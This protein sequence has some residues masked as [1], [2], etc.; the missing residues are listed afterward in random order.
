MGGALA[1]RA[2]SARPGERRG[3]QEPD[4]E[5]C[6][7]GVRE[8]A[9]PSG[10]PAR[11]R[12]ARRAPRQADLLAPPE[13]EGEA[14]A[15]VQNGA[16]HLRSRDEDVRRRE[17]LEGSRAP[18]PRR[19]SDRRRARPRS[20]RPEG[21]RLPVSGRV[22]RR[23]ALQA[24][25]SRLASNDRDLGLPRNPPRGAGASDMG[26]RGSRARRRPDP[27]GDEAAERARRSD[28][29]GTRA[30]RRRAANAVAPLGGHAQGDWR[31]R[32]RGRA[33][34]PGISLRRAAAP[35][36]TRGRLRTRRAVR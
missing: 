13:A 33:A 25:R 7:P 6:S 9:D 31:H 11:H 36:A 32:A 35:S 28:E 14:R 15:G 5:S 12:A 22:P 27:Q 26:G 10:Q 8:E 16:E 19:R 20:H 1:P 3:G 2:G 30:H 24:R 18:R 4:Q 29:D 21:A 34:A 17:E 23:C